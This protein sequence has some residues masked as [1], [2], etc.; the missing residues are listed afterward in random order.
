MAANVIPCIFNRGC[1]AAKFLF[2]PRARVDIHTPPLPAVEG[3]GGVRGG[4]TILACPVLLHGV[5]N[6]RIEAF[7]GVF[8][9]NKALRLLAEQI[10]EL[11]NEVD[12]LQ[13][14][15]KSL[16]MEFT[17]LYDKVSHQ[18]SRMA[19]RYARAEKEAGNGEAPEIPAGDDPTIDPISARI[20]RRRNAGGFQR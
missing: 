4:G 10:S 12:A 16:D 17:E 6:K 15:R 8:S 3:R 5:K 2:V 7:M 11:H 19:K 9:T 1:S 14:A 13:R 18:M 20:L